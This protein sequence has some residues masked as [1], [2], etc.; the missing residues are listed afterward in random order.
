MKASAAALLTLLLPLAACSSGEPADTDSSEAVRGSDSSTADPTESATGASSD[1][2]SSAP[3]ATPS[4]T[5]D[6]DLQA[7]A[8]KLSAG[9]SMARGTEELAGSGLTNVDQAAEPGRYELSAICVRGSVRLSVDEGKRTVKCDGETVGR[10]E[11]CSATA[12]LVY[13]ISKVTRQAG[14]VPVAYSITRVG[15]C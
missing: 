11:H 15:D 5:G 13:G 1:S 6:V 7:L 9:R 12:P 10:L 8:A 4:G 3:A 2:T 14:T